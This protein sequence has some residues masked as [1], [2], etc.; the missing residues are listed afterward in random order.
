MPYMINTYKAFKTINTYKGYNDIRTYK[1][2]NALNIMNKEMI[3]IN[4]IYNQTN[5]DI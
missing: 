5:Q 4:V 3:L 2:C 1:T